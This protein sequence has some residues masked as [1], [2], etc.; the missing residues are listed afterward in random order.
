MVLPDICPLDG[1]SGCK[2]HECHLYHVEWRTGD[3]HCII[4]YRA[5]HKLPSEGLRAVQ[6]T[7]ADSTR[8]RLGRDIPVAPEMKPPV[9]TAGDDVAKKEPIDQSILHHEEIVV[10]DKDTTVTQS[11]DPTVVMDNPV[12]G[13]ERDGNKKKHKNI[14]DAMKLDLPDNYEDEFWS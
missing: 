4:G 6:D 5:S 10:D 12:I 13:V 11:Y 14:D 7:Y 1:K 9:Q 8:I 3:E 2:K